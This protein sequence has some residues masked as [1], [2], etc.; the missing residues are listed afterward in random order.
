MMLSFYFLFFNI[1]KKMK[2][3]EINT[4]KDAQAYNGGEYPIRDSADMIEDIH[5]L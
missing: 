3:T 4:L 5:A 2:I 1:I